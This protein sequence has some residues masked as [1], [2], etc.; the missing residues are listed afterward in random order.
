MQRQSD[1]ALGSWAFAGNAGFWVDQER[2]DSLKTIHLAIRSNIRAFDTAYA[3]QNGRAEQMIGQQIKRFPLQRKEL[4][5]STKTMGRD[6]LQDSLKR[7]LTS[8]VDVWY[9]HWPS[10][11]KDIRPLLEKMATHKEAKMIGIC[12]V[13]PQYLE[14]LISSFPLKAVQIHCSLLWTRGMRE[15]VSFCKERNIFLSGYSPV[16]MGLLGGRHLTAPS[17][18]RKT[19]YCYD[20][21]KEF[22]TLLEGIRERALAHQCTMSQVA[23]AWARSQGFDQIVLGA[24]TKEQLAEDLVPLT[25]AREELAMLSELGDKLSALA[26]R[27]QDT[28]FAHRW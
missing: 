16:G 7:L 18:A 9:L 5:L 17:D 4:F 10:S 24:R 26:P 20:H 12:N 19:I 21:P 28:V 8:Y 2:G 23:I 27:W 3:Y 15:M 1:L 13:T 25:L 11:R 14:P 22:Q 6:N